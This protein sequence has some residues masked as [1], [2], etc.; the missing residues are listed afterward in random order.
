MKKIFP[1]ILDGIGYLFV[2]IVLYIF[3]CAFGVIDDVLGI[4]TYIINLSK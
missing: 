4:Y 1:Y 2:S 3:L